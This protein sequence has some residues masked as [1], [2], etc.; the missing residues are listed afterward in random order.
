M[1]YNK[2]NYTKTTNTDTYIVRMPSTILTLYLKL[3]QSITIKHE[4]NFITLILEM[5]E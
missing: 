5:A 4:T 3:T 1:S 2:S